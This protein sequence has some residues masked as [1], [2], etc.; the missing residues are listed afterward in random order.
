MAFIQSD[1]VQEQTTTTGTGTLTLAGAVTN[2]KTFS[3]RMATSDTCY[4]CIVDST[5]N[6]WEVGLGTL[7][8]SSTLG[9]TTILRSSN[10]DA[11][12][13]F[14][15]GT[16]NVFMTLP[17][18]KNVVV[19]DQ[20]VVNLPNIVGE[21]TIPP[22]GNL[23]LYSKLIAGKSLP[24][25]KG[26]SGLDTPLQ[27]AFW[28]NNIVLWN[29]STATAGVWQGAIGT[30]TSAGTFT[31]AAP[32]TT[33]LYTVQTRGRYANVITTANQVLGIRW[34]ATPTYFLG[35]TAGQGGFFFYCRMGLDVF[36]A[37]TRMFVGL[38]ASLTGTTVSADPSTIANSVGFAYDAADN[39]AIS[40]L[41]RSATTP[42]KTAT[43]FTAASGKGY[44]LYMFCAP[45]STT[46]GWRIDDTV[47]GTTA[48]GSVSA[49]PPA[50]NT[51][52]VPNVLASNAAIATATAV[53]IGI[54]RLYIE[55]DY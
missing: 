38:T 49:T 13:S 36:T 53:Q 47:A 52:M 11:A 51:M 22:A 37:A 30:T 40:F 43:G 23:Y 48:S 7:L 21:P 31:A 33:S 50:V 15:A 19:T 54:N 5:N 24:K 27:V 32:T 14:A 3:S 45:N 6:A 18:D 42:T 29:P 10:S 1:R 44:D 17:G 46:V 26:P 35:N 34:S 28:Q 41:M 9:R 8:S 16:K 55:T 39:G 2:F 20:A 25:I 4:Y 12:V